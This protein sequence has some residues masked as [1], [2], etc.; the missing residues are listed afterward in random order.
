MLYFQTI[1][2]DRFLKPV[3]I[4]LDI[5]KNLPFKNSGFDYLSFDI[6]K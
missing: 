3:R 6:T 4:K 1:N 5:Q 2:P